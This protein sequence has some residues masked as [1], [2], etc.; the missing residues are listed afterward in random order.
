VEGAFNLLD[1][2]GDFVV[3]ESWAK[4]QGSRLN[5]EGRKGSGLRANVQ[6]GAQNAVH[7]L[8]E[9]LTG[10]A[11]FGAE[12]GR[13]IVIESQGGSHIMMLHHQHHDVNRLIVVD[14]AARQRSIPWWR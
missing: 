4:A 9:G 3:T 11:G 10:L 6:A 5:L 12:L 14:L 7:D 2:F 1:E 8:L 13:Y